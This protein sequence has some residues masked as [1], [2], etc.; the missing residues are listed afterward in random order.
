MKRI[1]A[2]ILAVIIGMMASVNA[3]AASAQKTYISDLVAVAAKDEND[4]KAQLEK[5]GYKLLA[6]SNVNSSLKTGVYLGYKETDNADEAITDIAGM[7]M[8]GKFSYSDYK[9]IM[10]NNKEEIKETIDN[11][12]PVIAEFQANFEEERPAAVAAYKA[13]NVFKDDDSGKLM[14]DYL[15]DYDFSD[16]SQKKMTNTFMQAN[17]Q[18]ILGIMQQASFAGDDGEN[19]LADRLSK[20]G[21]KGIESKFKIYRTV[22][23]ANQAKEAEYGDTAAILY[24]DWKSLNDYIERAETAIANGGGILPEEPSKTEEPDG[25][26]QQVKDYVKGLEAAAQTVTV[27]D[28]AANLAL[29]NLLAITEYGDGTLLDFFRRPADE[30]KKEELYPLVDAMSEGQRSQ[31]DANGLKHTLECAFN[32]LE[33]DAEES[34]K[35]VETVETVA[36]AFEVTSI[37][38]GV[39]RSIFE[40]GVA[41]TSAATEHERTTGE[42]WITELTGIEA[43]EAFWY[44]SMITSLAV[45][46]VLVA[47]CIGA[48]LVQ[49]AHA[50]SL[51]NSVKVLNEAK[52]RHMDICEFCFGSSI[53]YEQDFTRTNAFEFVNGFRTNKKTPAFQAVFDKVESDYEMADLNNRVL[54]YS[55]TPAI[56]GFIK[57]ASLILLVVAVAAD[58]YTVYEYINAK[59]AQEEKIPHHLVTA[60]KTPYGEDYVYYATVKNLNGEAQDTNNHEADPKIG[61]LTLYTA[62][63]KAAGNPILTE[64]LKAQTG[65][66]DFKEGTAFIHLF[67]ET[68]ALNLTDEVYTGV[69]DGA[70]GTYILF[71][72]DA[73]ALAGS[74]ITGGTAAITGVGGLA[75]GA[76]IGALLAKLAGKKKKAKEI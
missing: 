57:C 23:A 55:S 3:F 34:K 43:D 49:R 7:N 38:E 73:S 40:D 52:E 15:L 48:A 54:K 30:V 33:K 6:G 2:V 46:G 8:T 71:S 65:S 32:S 64:N 76:V 59:N 61:W 69:K 1:L 10:E 26:S 5:A 50:S 14:G 25:V 31:A 35:A 74:A 19:T 58:I 53:T 44:K 36:E 37:F 27:A 28:D 13:M 12:E 51:K 66:T 18:I 41:F 75:V 42:S 11:F 9:T 67:N 45:S 72:R 62:K 60:V 21:P 47:T 20:L 29:Y 17:S 4:A 39:D 68:A 63:D 70:K 56:A 16:D 22:A 24:G